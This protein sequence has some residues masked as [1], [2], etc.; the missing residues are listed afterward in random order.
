M[1][2]HN[3]WSGLAAT[4]IMHSACAQPCAVA[5]VSIILSSVHC[6]PTRFV[7]LPSFYSYLAVLSF[8]YTREIHS[9]LKRVQTIENMRAL[10]IPCSDAHFTGEETEA[11]G[12]FSTTQTYSL[13]SCSRVFWWHDVTPAAQW[14]TGD[15]KALGGLGPLET[16]G[17]FVEV[18]LPDGLALAN[19]YSVV[20]HIVVLAFPL[21]YC[22]KER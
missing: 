13:W 21:R 22:R 10:V 12:T 14:L 20:P 9:H 16:I 15:T 5:R 1:I 19:Q 4:G 18:F 8:L 11:C 2:C 17:S 3:N 7:L 6:R